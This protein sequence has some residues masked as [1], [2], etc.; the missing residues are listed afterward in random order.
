MPMKRRGLFSRGGRLLDANTAES[1]LTDEGFPEPLAGI[2]TGESHNQDAIRS[3]VADRLLPA[4]VAVEFRRDPE[5][6]YD[7]NAVG[8][9]VGSHRVGFL[10][11]ELAADVAPVLDRAGVTSFTLAGR[12]ADVEGES[13]YVDVWPERRLTSAPQIRVPAGMM[14]S[15]WRGDPASDKQKDFIVSL[16]SRWEPESEAL[17]AAGLPDLAD[18]TLDRLSK[19]E[20]SAIIDRLLEWEKKQ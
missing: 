16:V 8:V 11:K 4:V 17:R 9:W 3:A 6:P 20:A 1:D 2:V 18:S 10:A 7:R 12:I 14:R 15:E 5:N 13:V 19:G